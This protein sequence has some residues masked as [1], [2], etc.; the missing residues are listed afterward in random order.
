MIFDTEDIINELLNNP[1]Y[2]GNLRAIVHYYFDICPSD[3][4][5]WKDWFEGM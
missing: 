4:K 2:R 5:D 3:L 1:E